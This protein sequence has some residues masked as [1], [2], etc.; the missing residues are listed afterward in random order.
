MLSSSQMCT[1]TLCGTTWKRHKG[2]QVLRL[3]STWLGAMNSVLGKPFIKIN[4]YRGI[5]CPSRFPWFLSKVAACCPISL[6]YTLYSYCL[7]PRW[8]K[9]KQ[10]HTSD[11]NILLPRIWLCKLHV[12]TSIW[13]LRLADRLPKVF[14]TDNGNVFGGLLQVKPCSCP[15]K[16]LSDE[17][18]QQSTMCWG[19]GPLSS[20]TNSDAS[21]LPGGWPSSGRGFS[22]ADMHHW[23]SIGASS[24]RHACEDEIRLSRSRAPGQETNM[25]KAR[26]EAL[27]KTTGGTAYGSLSRSV[28]LK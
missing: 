28:A 9:R 20:A 19:E 3:G 5:F 25:G 6:F 11:M 4:N 23:Q 26:K 22:E 13:K 8:D 10:K 2:H 17:S 24:E 12:F 15:M 14:L 7:P 1:S 27:S 21:F 16:S 18:L